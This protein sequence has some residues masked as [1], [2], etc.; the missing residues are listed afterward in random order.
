MTATDDRPSYDWRHNWVPLT[1][2]AALQ[3]AH[4]NRAYAE[5]LLGEAREDRATRKARK[6]DRGAVEFVPPT[7]KHRA[8]AAER[9]HWRAFTDDQLADQLGDVDEDQAGGIL[10]ELDR[11]DRVEKKAELQRAKR[12]AAKQSREDKRTA[13]FEAATDAGEDPEEAY[14]RIYGV[15]EE[16]RRRDEATEQLR[17]HGYAGK[18]FRAMV[19]QAHAAE[20]EDRYQHAEDVCRGSMLN[21]AGQRAG[22]SPHSLFSG[23]EAA[24][25]KYASEELRDYFRDY[26]RLTLEDFTVGLLEGRGKLATGRGGVW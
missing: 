10:A 14:S 11:R 8:A 7:P 5:Q 24:A 12:A 6:A 21:A 16:R 15:T 13:E 2:R 25:K 22:V 17:A 26:G 3:K 1:M 23:P 9:A 20:V 18:T 4:G 19:K